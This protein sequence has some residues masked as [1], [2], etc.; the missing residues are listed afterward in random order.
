VGADVRGLVDA[1]RLIG[2]ALW[3]LYLHADDDDQDDS[4]R[5]QPRHRVG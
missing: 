1:S 4:D 2:W 5:L 3:E